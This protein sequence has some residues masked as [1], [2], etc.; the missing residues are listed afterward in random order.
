MTRTGK[1]CTYGVTLIK[2]AP[3]KEAAIAFLD[4]LLDPNGGLKVL[5]S[6]G[7]P[8]FIPARAPTA[9]MKALL[10]ETLK[11]RVEVKN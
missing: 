5:E 8:P 11:K 9:E 10:P 4:Y 2:T 7:Q 6:M 3:N 1:S